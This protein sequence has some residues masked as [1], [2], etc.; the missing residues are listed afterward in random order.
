MDKTYQL[1]STDLLLGKEETKSK[2]YVRWNNLKVN[3]ISTNLDGSNVRKYVSTKHPENL[4]KE[5][6]HRVLNCSL[7]SF[8]DDEIVNYND[9]FLQFEFIKEIENEEEYTLSEEWLNY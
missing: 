9:L 7:S 3:Y 6:R 8:D 4:T 5:E 2:L 1:L